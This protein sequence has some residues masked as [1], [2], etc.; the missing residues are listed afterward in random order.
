MCKSLKEGISI[1]RRLEELIEIDLHRS[2]NFFEKQ[3]VED[4][5]LILLNLVAD[6]PEVSYYQGMNYLVVFCYYTCNKDRTMA[7]WLMSFMIEHCIQAYFGN[8]FCGLVKLL[9]VVDKLL[10]RVYPNIWSKL[11]RGGVTAIHFCVPTLITLF[12]SMIKSPDAYA[13][14]YEIWDC[15]ISR[16]IPPLIT[17]L[18]LL[19]EVQQSHLY[20][21][22]H[23]D[24]LLVM[25]NVEKDPFAVIRSA[26]ATG[27]LDNYYSGIGK[28][29]IK[30]V[31]VKDFTI[32]NM[33]EFYEAVRKK[34]ND[35][36]ENK[37][38]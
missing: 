29:H 35:T 4:A 34:I 37:G 6:Y 9:F 12:T 24:L 22:S 14:I 13:Y 10:Q 19:L 2:L 11:N 33:E 25:K 21:L 5:K 15:I 36:W 31:Q 1:D 18:L 7:Y 38:R 23:E 27:M 17:S 32:M 26:K 16:G 30:A 8:N 28:K 3:Y 20:T